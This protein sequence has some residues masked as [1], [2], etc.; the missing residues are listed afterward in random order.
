MLM[1]HPR[2]L[3]VEGIINTRPLEELLSYLQE[4]G[5]NGDW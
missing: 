5:T 2:H 1:R 3:S 4:R